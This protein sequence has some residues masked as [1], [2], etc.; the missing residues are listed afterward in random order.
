MVQVKFSKS[1]KLISFRIYSHS[2]C[3][4]YYNSVRESF[5]VRE[6]IINLEQI[7]KIALLVAIKL[8][9]A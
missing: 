2:A 1:Q 8:K 7:L 5:K 6:G 4:H 3:K 9:I